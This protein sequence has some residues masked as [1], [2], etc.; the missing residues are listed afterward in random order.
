MQ[1]GL[2]FAHRNPPQF[3]VP[4][5]RLYAETL[6]QVQYAEELGFD[7]AFV[8]EHHFGED[9]Y[10]P[11]LLPILA[12]WATCTTRIKLGTYV[13][14]LP[15]QNPLRFAEDAATVDI[16]S[17]GRLILG[18]GVG[19]RVEELRSF[20]VP[21]SSLG[22]RMDEA[23]EVLVRS[24][25]EDEFS[26]SGKHFRYP[27]VA[28]SPR[29]LQR[30]RPPIWVGSPGAPG[31]R[32]AARWGLEGFAGS[33]SARNYERYLAKCDEFGTE[34]VA[35]AQTLLFGHLNADHEE[36]WLEA[37]P[38]ATHLH[39]LYN[40]WAVTAGNDATFRHSPREDLVIGDAAHWRQRA[41]S[42]MS[43]SPLRPEYLIAQLQLPG[44]PHEVV[45]R[46]MELFAKELLPDFQ[47]AAAAD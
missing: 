8:S 20:D 1:V 41:A 26:F 43:G 28:L 19:Y 47:G 12:S 5:E 33:P 17:G 29:P 6:E 31:V 32:R 21:R 3:A 2:L 23:L 11:A 25:Q 46:S 10:S 27:E 37:E 15:L 18:L 44:M 35:Q 42:A 14:L 9:G 4:W 16:I 38:H 13:A 30:P 24:W 22:G 39:R 36:A 7:A 34:P 45:M 40:E